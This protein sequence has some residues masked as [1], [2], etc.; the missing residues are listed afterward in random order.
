MK[1]APVGTV[2]PLTYSVHGPPPIGR[3]RAR[4]RERHEPGEEALELT[5]V[6]PLADQPPAERLQLVVIGPGDPERAPRVRELRLD[7][8]GVPRLPGAL[9]LREREKHS[10]EAGEPERR[11]RDGDRETA[12]VAVAEAEER[13]HVLPL[14]ASDP[15]LAVESHQRVHACA[16]A[17]RAGADPVR[18]P[19]VGDRVAEGE[20]GSVLQRL[21]RLTDHAEHG[22]RVAADVRE[23][24]RHRDPQ[25]LVLA[26]DHRLERVL[27]HPPVQPGGVDHLCSAVRGV[28]IDR[29]HDVAPSGRAG[30]EPER[31]SRVVDPVGGL[32]CG[33]H[34]SFL[35]SWSGGERRRW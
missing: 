17:R 30:A 31:R 29:A 16:A 25:R 20:G 13:E 14:R 24:A 7:V 33:L 27:F 2:P 5:G 3:V 1:S 8:R 10:V 34:R 12:V 6:Q 32:L 23:V 19:R 22:A 18:A 4:L 21:V 9:R 26:F 35:L 15:D 11:D 28:G